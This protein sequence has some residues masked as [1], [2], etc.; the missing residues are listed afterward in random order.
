MPEKKALVY[1]AQPVHPACGSQNTWDGIQSSL[2][3]PRRIS[4]LSTG[5]LQEEFKS[6]YL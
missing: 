4:A 1:Q 3:L 6:W 2:A 5:T